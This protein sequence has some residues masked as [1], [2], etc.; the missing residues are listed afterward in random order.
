MKLILWVFITMVS[1][2]S[3]KNVNR[4]QSD[5]NDHSKGFAVVE[6]FTSEGCSSCPPA[7]EIVA[8]VKKEYGENVYV[9]SFHVDYWNYLGWKDEF[10]DRL[11]S[12]RQQ[13]YASV[14]KLES[15]YTPQVIVNGT[16]EFVGSDKSMLEKTITESL[17]TTAN[18]PIKINA[19]SKE[20]K[21]V[22]VNYEANIND[23]TNLNIALIQ[24]HAVSDVKRGENRGRTL[25]HV[26]V[27][28]NFKS[29]NL[30]KTG[31]GSTEFDILAGFDKDSYKV[32]AYLQD[33]NSLLITGVAEAAI[34]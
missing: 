9:L 26:N 23:K 28:R 1:F 33:K 5:D 16:R 12:A 34:K 13:Q 14:F 32:I 11:Y 7:D 25:K 29:I 24:L 4:Q 2:F 21:N 18:N 27:V 3:F 20:N 31:N 6:L 8:E 15:I 19:F 30:D 10:S 17:R 22:T